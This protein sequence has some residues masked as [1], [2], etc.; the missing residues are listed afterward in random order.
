MATTTSVIPE[1]L[2][3]LNTMS[4]IYHIP[5]NSSEID[6]KKT[7][8]DVLINLSIYV[9]PEDKFSVKFQSIFKPFVKIN[10]WSYSK[11]QQ[12]TKS[13]SLSQFEIQRNVA[14]WCST[15]GCGIAMTHILG[16]IFADAPEFKMISQKN[17]E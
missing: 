13:E 1:Q 8:E 4:P 3:Q 15:S 7:I 11:L 14:V 9:T 5:A 2:W 6:V 16:H 17:K 10:T 12:Y